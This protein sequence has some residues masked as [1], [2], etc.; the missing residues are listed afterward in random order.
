MK[1]GIATN[2]SPRGPAHEIEPGVVQLERFD[3]IRVIN[4]ETGEVADNVSCFIW[5]PGK[6]FTGAIEAPGLFDPEHFE[7]GKSYVLMAF[8]CES[9]ETFDKPPS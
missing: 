1:L 4:V 6:G 9:L 5:G 2:R 7:E 3:K 8:P